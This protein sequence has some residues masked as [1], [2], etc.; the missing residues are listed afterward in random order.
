M[1]T[2][3]KKNIMAISRRHFV[4]LSGI[5]ALWV[6]CSGCFKIKT[7][8]VAIVID[9]ADHIA[10]SPPSQWAVKELETS[11]MSEGTTVYR[12]D[13]VAQ[14]RSGDLCIIVAGSNASIT[15]QLL[16]DS[17][18]KIP[19]VAEALGLVPLKTH[20]NLI[21]LACGYDVRGLVY[22]LLELA[23]RVKNSNDP[24]KSLHSKYCR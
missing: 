7:K 18:I 9:P 21:L 10:C 20:D 22:A 11:L 6:S 2:D 13:Q 14:A 4:K 3:S 19:Y 15:R 8:D 16:K 17:K 12:C 1:K 5:S 23:D 24:L